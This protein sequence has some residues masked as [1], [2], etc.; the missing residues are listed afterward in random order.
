MGNQKCACGCDRPVN[1]AG[2]C[3]QKCIARLKEENAWTAAM[4]VCGCF[5]LFLFLFFLQ[6]AHNKAVKISAEKH[7]ERMDKMMPDKKAANAART[8]R[9]KA[10]RENMNSSGKLTDFEFT[11]KEEDPEGYKRGV[12]AS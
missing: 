8:K 10:R 6:K 7:R 4:E 2:K 5:I 9:N 12:A 1:V 11:G 3:Q